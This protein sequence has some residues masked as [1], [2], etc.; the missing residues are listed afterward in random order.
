M[1]GLA[2]CLWALVSAAHALP[3]R[4]T[5][6]IGIVLGASSGFGLSL[7]LS[8]DPSVRTSLVFGTI[9][10]P[11]PALFVSTG[12]RIEVLAGQPGRLRPMMVC[13]A[14]Y[15]VTLWGWEGYG[16][17]CGPGI[18]LPHRDPAAPRVSFD[19]SLT[20]LGRSGLLS[21]TLREQSR[22]FRVLPLPQV[23]LGFTE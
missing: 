6:E 10:G 17:G 1:G 13:G 4:V 14:G 21:H 2:G 3:D 22:P 12:V 11:S 7:G 5:P 23:A 20:V 18:E 8:F 16:L 9:P 19:T 15:H